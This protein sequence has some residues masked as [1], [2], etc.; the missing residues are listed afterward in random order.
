MNRST[1]ASGPRSVLVLVRHGHTEMAGTFCGLSDPPLSEEG[2]GQLTAMNERLKQYPITHI[3]SSKLRRARQTAA[4]IAKC[5][6]LRIRYLTSLRELA[7][8]S[9]EGLTWDQVMARD[10]EYA[11][12]WL[13]RYPDLR[14]PEGENFSNFSRRIQSAMEAIVKQADN[15]CAAVVTHAGVIRTFLGHVASVQGIALELAQ[16]EYASCWEVRCEAGQWRMSR[17]AIPVSAQAEAESTSA[18]FEAVL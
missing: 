8:G 2:L 4:S 1:D 12:R 16:C 7:F 3:F 14:A 5:R 10:P 18:D 9:W 13:D 6:G 17:G 11:Q 15:G